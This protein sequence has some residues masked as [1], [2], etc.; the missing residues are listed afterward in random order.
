MSTDRMFSVDESG[1]IFENERL[2]RRT[3]IVFT[4]DMPAEV[5]VSR[6]TETGRYKSKD[7]HGRDVYSEDLYNHLTNVILSNNGDMAT[8]FKAQ[9]T[10]RIIKA[11]EALH[12]FITV[13][14][15]MNDKSP[16]DHEY[17]VPMNMKFKD[18]TVVSWEVEHE[19]E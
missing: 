5:L 4:I 15:Y 17:D 2:N 18:G 7:I 12:S 16:G 1:F 11:V 6:D 13:N 3:K 10:P 14:H 19:S 9:R 8:V